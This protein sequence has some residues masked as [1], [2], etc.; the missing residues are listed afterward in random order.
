[1]FRQAYLISQIPRDAEGNLV[2][3]NQAQLIPILAKG[4]M[5]GKL[6]NRVKYHAARSTMRKHVHCLQEEESRS[7]LADDDT[8]EE[9]R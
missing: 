9:A 8:E 4:W 5:S 3:V 1:M 2:K 6:S 7:D